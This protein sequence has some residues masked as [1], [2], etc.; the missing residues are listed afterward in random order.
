[1]QRHDRHVLE[2][3][4]HYQFHPTPRS[5]GCGITI[6]YKGRES[7][8]IVDKLAKQGLSRSD[9]FIAWV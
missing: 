2:S 4:F 8:V 1:M 3:Q 9:E 7:N 6:T 5:W